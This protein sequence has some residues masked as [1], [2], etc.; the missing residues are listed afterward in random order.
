MKKITNENKGRIIKFLIAAMGPGETAQGVA[1]TKYLKKRGKKVTFITRLKLNRLFFQNQKNKV[2]LVNTSEKFKKVFEKEKPDILVLCNSKMVS[3]YKNFLEKR[4][5]FNLIAVSLDSNWLFLKGERWYSFAK[6]LDKYLIV[7]PEKIFKLGLKKYGGNY[8]IPVSIMRKIETVGFIPSYKKPP[9]KERLNIR[10]KYGIKKG[11]KLIFAYFGGF[12]AG[13]RFWALENLIKAINNLIKKGLKIKI[14]YIGPTKNFESK[15]LKESWLIIKRVLTEREFFLTLSSSNLVF[16]H[17]G[18]GTL[19]QAISS[20]TPVIVNVR[21][22]KDEP[23]PR[24][25]HAWEIAPF[26]KLNLCKMFY[27]SSPIEEIGEEIRKLLYEKKGRKAMKEAQRKYYTAGEPKVYQI[28]KELL[29]TKN[30]KL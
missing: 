17:Q 3:Y 19:A 23:Y 8:T 21:G 4:P 30:K 6:W 20:Q 24:N 9:L 1:L 29:M 2:L 28:I 15:I 27:A 13:F 5:S 18:I 12:G 22:L 26:A 7:F 25:A 14:I 11:E 16:Q 10:K